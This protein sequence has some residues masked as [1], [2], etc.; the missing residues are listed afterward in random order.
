MASLLSDT[1]VLAPLALACAAFFSSAVAHGQPV[2]ASPPTGFVCTEGTQGNRG[3]WAEIDWHRLYGVNVTL[4]G[5]DERFVRTFFPELKRVKP[6]AIQL[7]LATTLGTCRVDEGGGALVSCE[8]D[9]AITATASLT[10]D[11]S[12]DEISIRR[13]VSLTSVKLVIVRT[14]QGAL[15]MQVSLDAQLRRRKATYAFSR[16]FSSLQ[17]RRTSGALAGPV[18]GCAVVAGIRVSDLR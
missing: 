8:A 2:A 17:A 14:P 7:A 16:T 13:S 9:R 18:N 12:P 11:R 4:G 5:L 1:R 6:T 15:D 3:T 10:Y